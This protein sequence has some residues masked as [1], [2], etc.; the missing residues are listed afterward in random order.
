MPVPASPTRQEATLPPVPPRSPSRNTFDELDSHAGPSTRPR[1]ASL[2]IVT[3]GTGDF[4]NLQRTGSREAESPRYAGTFNAG[5]R[6]I[7]G[8]DTPRSTTP[9]SSFYAQPKRERKKP[10]PVNPRGSSLLDLNSH[11]DDITSTPP[12]SDRLPRSS[13]EGFDSRS[14]STGS[15]SIRSRASIPVDANLRSMPG[16]VGIG[17]GWAGGPQGQD[18]KRRL[19]FRR[20]S[21]KN[22]KVEEDPLA[23]WSIQESGTEHSPVGG[24]GK[25]GQKKGLFKEAWNRSIGKFGSM[26]ALVSGDQLNGSG[27]RNNGVK[28]LFSKSKLDLVEEKAGSRR[29]DDPMAQEKKDKR[30][31]VAFFGNSKSQVELTTPRARPTSVMEPTRVDLGSPSPPSP[32]PAPRTTPTLNRQGSGKAEFTFVAPITIPERDTRRLSAPLSAPA[33]PGG[34]PPPWR[35]SSFIIPRPNGSPAPRPFSRHED[36]IISEEPGELE[37]I[38]D[39]TAP[40]LLTGDGLQASFSS[41]G[42]E[43]P[44]SN[45]AEGTSLRHKRSAHFSEEGSGLERPTLLRPKSSLARSTTPYTL[46]PIN[47]ST[48]GLDTLNEWANEGKRPLSRA[49]RPAQDAPPKFPDPPRNRSQTPSWVPVSFMDRIKQ[50]FS[51][52]NEMPR[53]P[54]TPSGL[55]KDLPDLPSRTST[56]VMPGAYPESRA[57]T[58]GTMMKDDPLPPSPYDITQAVA[59]QMMATP[60]PSRPSSRA[61]GRKRGLSID[62]LSKRLNLGKISERDDKDGRDGDVDHTRPTS[63]LEKRNSYAMLAGRLGFGSRRNSSGAEQSLSMTPTD[64]HVNE[65]THG[66]SPFIP[67]PAVITPLPVTDFGADD[68]GLDDILDESR[69]MSLIRNLEAALPL[70]PIRDPVSPVTIASSP[71]TVSSSEATILA[72]SPGRQEADQERTPGHKNHPSTST[73]TTFDLDE[74]MTPADIRKSFERT[75]EARRGSQQSDKLTFDSEGNIVEK[76]I[77][78]KHWPTRKHT[79]NTSIGE[80]ASEIMKPRSGL[81]VP[82]AQDNSF[83]RG[84]IVI[85]EDEDE[86]R[87]REREERT[88]SFASQ[89]SDLSSAMSLDEEEAGM[90]VSVCLGSEADGV[91]PMSAIRVASVQQVKSRQMELGHQIRV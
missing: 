76:S 45:S 55:G 46:T 82:H 54:A 26:P 75:V 32:S 5:P 83:K 91:V 49:F 50:V 64:R 23:L 88:M 25:S 79:R 1:P 62:L 33:A 40:S 85:G 3:S 15:H 21:S 2:M 47:D 72:Q 28:G 69:R 57:A 4:S 6:S 44:R 80:L 66:V 31:T 30:R 48:P 60:S 36:R 71:K 9:A 43:T 8:S 35:P 17:E 86:M 73:S 56:P 34:L 37:V 70:P 65:Y 20:K 39:Q 11:V 27:G 78:R 13:D 42:I 81:K 12:R 58:P 84:S 19:W 51:G 87:I 24:N 63:R 38:E 18:K 16:V 90:L 89:I 10:G 14:N 22:N 53:R 77:S 29:P 67:A 61:E 41:A 59:R 74:L 7:D 68:L 52:T